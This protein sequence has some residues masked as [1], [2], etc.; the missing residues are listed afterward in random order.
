MLESENGLE[1]IN[2]VLQHGGLQEDLLNLLEKIRSL[3]LDY[4]ARRA[5]NEPIE[6]DE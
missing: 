2:T 1:K 4:K 5:R 3:T 6:D